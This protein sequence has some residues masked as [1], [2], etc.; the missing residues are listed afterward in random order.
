MSRLVYQIDVALYAVAA[1]GYFASLWGGRDRLVRL[2][3]WVLA[4]AFAL[5]VLLII[6]R[7]VEGGRAPFA[8]LHESLSFFVFCT[9]GLFFL[10]RWKYRVFALGYV[11]SPLALILMAV[12]ALQDHSVRPLPPVLE[13]YWLPLH[14]TL[15]FMAEGVLTLSFAA[16]ILY[17]V[18]ERRIK[19]KNPVL[20]FHG[21]SSLETLDAVNY[22]CL[23][24][25]FP[26]LTAGIISGSVWASYAWGSYW[27]WDPKETWSLVTWLIYAALLHQRLNAG[28]RGRKA[29][30]FAILGFGF[31]IFTF[32]GVNL[33]LP[34]LHSYG[35]FAR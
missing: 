1:L 24:L 31:V 15:S 34:G 13:S 27:S 30:I 5:Q 22:R 3:E 11:V 7:V 4:L 2:G 20:Q 6:W 29:A 12:A 26:L 25:G 14:G 17:L 32:L 35:E 33:L 21:L 19:R 18:Q 28:W 9:V 8:N 16:A 23:G 10:L